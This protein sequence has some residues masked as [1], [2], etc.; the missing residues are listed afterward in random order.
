MDSSSRPSGLAT[1]I[2]ILPAGLDDVADICDLDYQAFPEESFNE[3]TIANQL[4]VGGGLMAR[5]GSAPLGYA[6]LGHSSDLTDLIRLGVAES[7]RRR[8]VG[9]RLLE[10][11]C[12]RHRHVMLCCRYDNA[13]A[14]TLYRSAGFKIVGELLQPSGYRAWVMTRT[15]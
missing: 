12:R 9:R 15:S 6:L 14:L 11:V 2:E 5:S 8:G 10:E 13:P 3:T 7:A 4:T 1:E